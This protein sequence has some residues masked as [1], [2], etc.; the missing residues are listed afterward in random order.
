MQLLSL[1]VFVKLYIRCLS[2]AHAHNNHAQAC[3]DPYLPIII[4]VE[5]I[6]RHQKDYL[7]IRLFN[8]SIVDI[9]NVVPPAARNILRMRTRYAVDKKKPRCY[10]HAIAR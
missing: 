4:G 6:G 1:W 5:K 8:I 2:G 3:D 9:D 10:W 7:C